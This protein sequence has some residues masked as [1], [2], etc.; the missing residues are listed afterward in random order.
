MR[1]YGRIIAVSGLMLVL[2][3]GAWGATTI[4]GTPDAECDGILTVKSTSAPGMTPHLVVNTTVD[5]GTGCTR[6]A[7]TS[8]S[9][10]MY[11]SAFGTTASGLLNKAACF[12]GTGDRL[13][14]G[15]SGPIVMCANNVTT[16][17]GHLFIATTGNVGIGTATPSTKLEV[18]GEAKVQVINI[19]GGSDLSEAFEV[20]DATPGAVVC[21]DA[22]HPG[23]LVVSRR[24]YDRTVAGIVSGA[25]DLKT[26]VTM[27]QTGTLADG[28]H[29]VAL[30]GRVYCKVDATQAAVAPGDLL[31]TSSTPGHAMKATDPVQRQGAILGKAMT[32]LAKGQ[33]GLVLVL[34]TLQ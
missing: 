12:W 10:G 15:T 25:G 9:A 29:A 14:I 27:G 18:A 17:P 5:P 34:V 1:R 32:P 16:S 13:V 31:T 8:P 2:A 7:V 23:R 4:I 11:L 21:I 33:T 19:T 20:T 24:P 26:G 3:A 30:T 28:K 22:D 6:L